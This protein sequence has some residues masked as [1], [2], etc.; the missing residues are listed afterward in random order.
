M[1]SSGRAAQA[2]VHEHAA[3]ERIDHYQIESII[4]AG[5]MGVVYLAEDLRLKRPVA[6][7]FLNDSGFLNDS[8][9]TSESSTNRITRE[10][11]AA[12]ALNHPGIC[13]I[14]DVGENDGAPY[15]VMEFVEGATLADLIHQGPLKL[16]DL[17]RIAIQIAAAVS[18]AHERGIIH[19]DLKPANIKIKADGSVKILDFG[20]AKLTQP[21]GVHASMTTLNGA[22]IGTAAYMSPE[23]AEGKPLDARTDIFS[24]GAVLYEMATGRR[25]FPGDSPAASMAAIL[26]TDPVPPSG[27]VP[28]APLV[29]VELG[30]IIAR[31]LRK[32][33]A[34]R[35]QHMA[36]V[37]V[38]LE[39]FQELKGLQEKDFENPPLCRFAERRATAAARRQTDLRRRNRRTDHHC[40]GDRPWRKSNPARTRRHGSAP[41]DSAHD[42]RGQRELPIV[43][44][45]RQPG[46]LQLEWRKEGQLG[47][48]RENDLRRHG[49]APDHRRRRTIFFPRGPRTART[50]RF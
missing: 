46:R 3:S 21:G 19:R 15:M 28:S 33:P 35:F 1:P 24:F 37:K 5:G 26:L 44:A 41:R 16:N 10:A 29:P 9:S 48:L 17:L 6:I 47:P 25:A 32:D 30:R 50:S 22:V 2:A 12:S 42:L 40:R 11:Q 49:A 8:R 13:T 45:R 39:E 43:F 31:C 36:D 38:L 27:A 7:K 4:G 18:A 20:L 14:Y 34:N 23:Q